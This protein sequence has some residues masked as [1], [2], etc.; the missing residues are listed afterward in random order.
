[1]RISKQWKERGC[2]LLKVIIPALIWRG[3]ERPR[4]FW[5]TDGGA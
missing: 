4:K 1:M 2:V 3:S 5:V